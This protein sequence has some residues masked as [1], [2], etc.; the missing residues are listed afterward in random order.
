VLDAAEAPATGA[1]AAQAPA[2]LRAV[3]VNIDPGGDLLL[4][5]AASDRVLRFHLH[6]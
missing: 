5:D 6:L 1:A 2:K 4:L 3:A